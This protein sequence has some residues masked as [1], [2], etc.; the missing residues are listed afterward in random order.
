[1]SGKYDIGAYRNGDPLLS[2]KSDLNDN[3][4]E[5]FRGFFEHRLLNLRLF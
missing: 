1:M 4:D 3:F 2:L 5:K